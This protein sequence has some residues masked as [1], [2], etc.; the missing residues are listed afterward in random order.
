MGIEALPQEV[1]VSVVPFMFFSPKFGG[2]YTTDFS[3]PVSLAALRTSLVF[4]HRSRGKCGICG[5]Y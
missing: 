5:G 1:W 4:C 2:N 3:D